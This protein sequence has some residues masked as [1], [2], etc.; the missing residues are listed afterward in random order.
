MHTLKVHVIGLPRFEKI[1]YRSIVRAGFGTDLLKSR[2]RSEIWLNAALE[3]HR[4][5]RDFEERGVPPLF[6]GLRVLSG[7]SR[8][9]SIKTARSILAKRA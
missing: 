5:F 4:F 6:V 8:S 7:R 3:G 1:A 2:L 9:S